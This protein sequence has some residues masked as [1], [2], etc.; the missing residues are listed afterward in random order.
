[1]FVC[2]AVARRRRMSFRP[3]ADP[4]GPSRCVFDTR[5]FGK[6]ERQRFRDRDVRDGPNRPVREEGILEAQAGVTKVEWTIPQNEP[7]AFGA[8]QR[9]WQNAPTESVP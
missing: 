4:G 2:R 3:A 5:Q 7:T 1:M 8:S 9:I 6:R